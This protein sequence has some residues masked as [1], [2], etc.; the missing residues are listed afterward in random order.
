MTGENNN[1]KGLKKRNEGFICYHK[2]NMEKA[3]IRFTVLIS[4]LLNFWLIVL[5]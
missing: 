1:S 5:T 3:F 2:S 4:A